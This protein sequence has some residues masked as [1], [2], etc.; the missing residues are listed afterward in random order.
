[1]G[2]NGTSVRVLRT[3]LRGAFIF[4][5]QAKEEKPVKGIHQRGGGEAGVQSRTDAKRSQ[6]Q[7]EQSREKQVGERL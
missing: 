6:R 2:K 5:S 4:R 1:M 7:G 3:K